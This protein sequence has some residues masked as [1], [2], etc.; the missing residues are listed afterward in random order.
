MDQEEA[1]DCRRGEISNGNNNGKYL[2]SR[3]EFVIGGQ[4]VKN[5][6][7]IWEVGNEETKEVDGD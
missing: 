1:G 5:V 6:G 4:V 7:N 2:F 3:E